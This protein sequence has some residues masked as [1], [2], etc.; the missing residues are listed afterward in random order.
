[1]AIYLPPGYPHVIENMGRQ[2]PVTMLQV[3]A[4]PGP[5]RVYRD[6]TNAEAR[7]DFEVIRDP[8]KVKV[9]PAAKPVVA[10]ASEVKA[11]PYLGGKVTARIVFDQAVTGDGALA[12][13][14]I[15]FAAGADVPRHTHDTSAELLYVLSGG[16][17][18]TIGSE[19]VPFGPEELVYVPRGQ[20]HAVKFAANDKTVALQ[21]YAPAGPEQ[22][23][24]APAQAPGA[25]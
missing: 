12:F 3:F 24:K 8:S 11:L 7:A 16:G 22:R 19:P 9:D 10:T 25:K 4:P 6:P 14:V 21:I 2:I 23:F 5:E 20:P 13:D 1:M 17:T 18:L 15:E